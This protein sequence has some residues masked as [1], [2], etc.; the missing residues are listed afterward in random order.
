M[1][2]LSCSW[3]SQACLKF[4]TWNVLKARTL[5]AIWGPKEF[6]VVIFSV[7][8]Y[9]YGG[10]YPSSLVNYAGLSVGPMYGHWEVAGVP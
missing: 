4:V 1:T 5:E 7:P 2:N 8:Y 3:T 9:S 6:T 10:I